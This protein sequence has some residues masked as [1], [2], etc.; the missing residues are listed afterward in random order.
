MPKCN[1]PYD[2]LLVV[3]VVEEEEEQF[4]P[5]LVQE[6]EKHG[7]SAADVKKLQVVYVSVL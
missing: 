6:L 4:G 1:Y 7:I 2:L 3:Q 5:L